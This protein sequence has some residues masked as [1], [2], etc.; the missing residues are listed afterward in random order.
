LR[1]GEARTGDEIMGAIIA[2]GTVIVVA[3]AVLVWVVWIEMNEA[4]L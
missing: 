3:F 2:A 4:G 1:L